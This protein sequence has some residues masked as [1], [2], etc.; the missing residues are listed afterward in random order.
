MNMMENL[1]DDK[2][3][4]SLID[5]LEGRLQPTRLERIQKSLQG[6]SK[7]LKIVLED[8]Y[9]PHNANAVIRSCDAMGVQDINIIEN[10]N[11]FAINKGVTKGSTKW[12][13]LRRYSDNADVNTK[14]CIFDLKKDGFKVYATSLH[15][16][17]ISL[18]L[19]DP[20]NKIAVIFGSEKLGVSRE[21]IDLA[22][23]VLQVPMSGFSESMNISVSAGI[24]I[25]HLSQLMSKKYGAKYFTQGQEKEEIYIKFLLNSVRAKDKLVE[26]FDNKYFIR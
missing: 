3:R 25:Y 7:N 14:N 10:R 9:D 23:G 4:K 20:P 26:I 12:V 2:Y 16:K 5:Y 18:P 1:H 22:D 21:A 8:I 15:E 11:K 6:R 19:L 24:I 17:S 13:D